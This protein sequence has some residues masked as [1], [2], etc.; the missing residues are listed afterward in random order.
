MVAMKWGWCGLLGLQCTS[1]I[2]SA[3]IAVGPAGPSPDFTFAWPAC[4]PELERVFGVQNHGL[5][6]SGLADISRNLTAGCAASPLNALVDSGSA[7]AAFVLAVCCI[8]FAPSNC[9]HMGG[10]RWC[11]VHFQLACVLAWGFVGAAVTMIF[12]FPARAEQRASTWCVPR[13]SESMMGDGSSCSVAILTSYARETAQRL[14][15]GCQGMSISTDAL[16]M[17]LYPS[18]STTESLARQTRTIFILHAAG[19]PVLALAIAVV[20]FL[21]PRRLPTTRAVAPEPASITIL[22]ST[23]PI[24]SVS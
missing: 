4:D 22:E 12:Y 14:A 20:Y 1:V 6:C 5:A 17:S 13:G 8:V 2:L 3:L 7:L 24:D 11:S 23:A 19:A 16:N 21:A 15:D 10:K 18:A 9:L